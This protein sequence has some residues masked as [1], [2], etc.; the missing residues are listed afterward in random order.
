MYL[1]D[2]DDPEWRAGHVA[3]IVDVDLENGLVAL[4]EENYD[5]RAWQAPKRLRPADFPVRDQWAIHPAGHTAGSAHERRRRA[6]RRLGLS[7]ALSAPRRA[8][9]RPACA[10][11]LGARRRRIA[12]ALAAGRFRMNIIRTLRTR[13]LLMRQWRASDFAPFADLNG[14]G[15][16]M[17]YFPSVLSRAPSDAMAQRCLALIEERGWGFWATEEATSGRFVGFIG[18]HIP[19]GV[20]PFSPCVEVGWRLARAYWGKGLATEGAKAA[21]DFAFEELGLEDVVSFTSVRN[22]KSEAVMQRLGMHRD[23]WTFAHPSIASGHWLSEHCLYRLG[24]PDRASDRQASSNTPSALSAPAASRQR[25][26]QPRR[27]A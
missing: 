11:R 26:I 14:D 19:A 1:A 20:F 9:L 10:E 25:S 3:V 8:R 5:N 22:A 27:R 4:A 17:R 6:D 16:T 13:R 7:L 21:L 24:N 23:P 12:L 18:L 2:R 15:E